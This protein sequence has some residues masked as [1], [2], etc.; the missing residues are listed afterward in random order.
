MTYN[1]LKYYCIMASRLLEI[2]NGKQECRFEIYYNNRSVLL[3]Y[4][5]IVTNG[6]Y[7]QSLN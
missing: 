4:M 5:Y 7:F 3:K 6:E 1:P 2:E